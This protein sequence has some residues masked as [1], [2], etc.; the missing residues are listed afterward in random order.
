LNRRRRLLCL[1]VETERDIDI[2]REQELELFSGL[3]KKKRRE[4][5]AVSFLQTE[6]ERNI[7]LLSTCNSSRSNI[8]WLFKEMGKG[9]RKLQRVSTKREEK[10]AAVK[11]T[12]RRAFHL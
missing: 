3:R 5:A 12:E 8:D 11:K 10:K 6:K 9:R 2:L 4:A 1:L 7:L